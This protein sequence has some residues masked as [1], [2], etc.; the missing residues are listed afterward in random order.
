M[1]SPVD[2]HDDALLRRF[3]RNEDHDAFA[4][5]VRRYIGLVYAAAR[6]QT[7]GD[8]HLADDVTQAVMIV[9]AR[10]AGSITP[11]SILASWL[12]VVT[13]HCAQNALKLRARQ[14]IHEHRAA[15]VRADEQR[16]QSP[17]PRSEDDDLS[18]ALHAAIAR[19]REPDRA[20]VVLHYFQ[21]RTHQQVGDALGLS[22]G[23]ARKRVERAVEKMRLMLAGRCGAAL[24]GAAVAATIRAEASAAFEVPAHLAGSSFNVAILA[25]SAPTAAAGAAPAIAQGVARMFALAKFKAAAAVLLL[26]AVGIPLA[27]L[28]AWMLTTV[29][30]TSPVEASSRQ[31]ATAPADGAFT[32]RVTPDI[33]VEFLGVAPHPADETQW[34]DISGEPI[35]IPLP[36]LT[37][38]AVNTDSQP[39]QQ[40][41]IRL[42]HPPGTQF[43]L[44]T[45]NTRTSSNRRSDL[46]G[47]S[48]LRTRFALADPAETLS[49]RIGVTTRPWEAVAEWEPTDEPAEV[50]AGKFGPITIHP[51]R[52]AERWGKGC[53]TVRHGPVHTAT[54]RM[55]AVDD[56]GNRHEHKLTNVDTQNDEWETT[57][58]M[59]VP[60]EK[61]K[62]VILEVR[63]FDK[64]VVARDIALSP[65]A[66]TTPKID[67]V[68]AAKEK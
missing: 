52:D 61:I 9:L 27:G 55:I 1:Y 12:L 29:G 64:F 36:Q 2:N 45:D 68:D 37:D 41:A 11:G 7:R 49:L 34:H 26:G 24:S 5:L 46:D 20:G 44:T 56:A 51:P 42:T 59:D 33:R 8:A 21:N 48:L 31:P 32:A 39:D 54:A 14:R 3:A 66:R 22:A 62:R 19:L 50:D 13:R 40:I 53:V 4:E 67:V 30:A 47:G 38:N 17:A 60:R 58:V 23:A 43:V 65:D 15:V 10:R 25:G 6:R 18:E 28:G 57:F 35:D 16:A 63:E